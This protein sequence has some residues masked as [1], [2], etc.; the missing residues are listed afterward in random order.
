MAPKE[1]PQ[2]KA[3]REQERRLAQ[4]ERNQTTQDLAADLTSDYARLY[5]RGFSVF[6]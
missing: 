2:A 5:N 1:D 4:R 3:I 6:R